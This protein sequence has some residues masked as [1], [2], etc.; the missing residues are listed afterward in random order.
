MPSFTHPRDWTRPTTRRVVAVGVPALLLSMVPVGVAA[1]PD[2]GGEATVVATSAAPVEP[3]ERPV[4]ASRSV[5]RRPLPVAAPAPEPAPVEAPA[6]EPTV[7]GTRFTTVAL[8]VRT[9]PAGDADVVTVLARGAEVG[10]TGAAEGPWAQVLHAGAVAWVSGEY[11]AD[12]PPAPEPEPEP[13]ASAAPSAS[14]GGISGAA[15]PVSSGIESGLKANAVKVYRAVC[16]K[17]PQVKSY[18]GLRPGDSGEHG[19]GR[20]LD[21]MI[22]GSTGDA[23]AAWVRENHQAL[24]VSEVIWS[25]RIWTVE[26][27]GDGWRPMS[28]RGS[29]TANHYDHVHVTTY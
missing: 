7:V 1:W 4:R 22:S 13:T 12:T 20:A 11:L 3:I 19:S 23:I 24:G 25:Q 16:A 14:S 29:A 8:K 6:P 5:E 15:C 18:G 17:F 21:I 10:V 27:S 26:R 2:D 9:G 28:D